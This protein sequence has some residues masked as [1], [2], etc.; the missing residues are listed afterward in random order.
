[1]RYTKII[2]VVLVMITFLTYPQIALAESSHDLVGN[3]SKVNNEVIISSLDTSE[4]VTQNSTNFGGNSRSALIILKTAC[5]SKAGTNST[6]Q[7]QLPKKGGG[8]TNWVTLG[9][10]GGKLEKCDEDYY[11]VTFSDVVT[12]DNSPNAENL[13]LRTNSRGLAPSWKLAW[14]EVS[15]GNFNKDKRTWNIWLGDKKN[16]GEWCVYNSKGL[17]NCS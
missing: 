14:T 15:I 3:Q 9:D 11:E 7:A 16:K 4:T 17:V 13:R 5:E 12:L 6:I 10:P 8:Y 1:M 2:T